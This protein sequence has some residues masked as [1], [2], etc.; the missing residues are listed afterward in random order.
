MKENNIVL[1]LLSTSVGVILLF[2]LIHNKCYSSLSDLILP[3]FLS[4]VL[5]HFLLSS[6]QQTAQ[7]INNIT[8]IEKMTQITQTIT[9]G[10]QQFANNIENY[11]GDKKM[12]N[13]KIEIGAGANISGSF[14][15][16]SKIEHS[17]N[18]LQESKTS[19]EVK[20]LLAQLL[21]EIKGLTD[22]VEPENIQTVE[23]M[24]DDVQDMIDE[25]NEPH[26]R[27]RIILNYLNTLKNKAV[28]AAVSTDVITTIIANFM[29]IVPQ[30]PH[31]L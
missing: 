15:V 23:E 8:R 6:N 13:Q 17:F 19:N 18:S 9:G 11:N 3:V 29:T 27:R 31:L 28:I 25:L 30:L 20:E 10:E 26:P 24:V 7:Q 4:V 12:S 1:L 21:N 22:K 16:D 5:Y 2:L 14:N